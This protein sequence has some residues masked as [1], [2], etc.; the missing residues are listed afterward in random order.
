MEDGPI[1]WVDRPSYLRDVKDPY[2]VWVVGDSMMPRYRPAQILHVHPY[3]PPQPGAG[4]V[5]CKR[6]GAVL[7]KE[8]VGRAAEGVILREYQPQNRQF[9]VSYD[10][11]DKVHTVV[12]SQEA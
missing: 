7:I 12:G 11:L 5:V 10:E 2:A 1:D 6:S 3:R 9:T 4:V 8:W